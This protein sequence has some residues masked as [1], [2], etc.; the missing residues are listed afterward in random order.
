ML[1]PPR[2]PVAPVIRIVLPVALRSGFLGSMEGYTSRRKLL[3]N[4]K[5]AVNA[6]GSMVDVYDGELVEDF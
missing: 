5:G 1:T 3:V 4:W 2:P 6:L